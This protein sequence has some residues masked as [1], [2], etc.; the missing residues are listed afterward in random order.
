M[1]TDRSCRR[2]T[3]RFII[4]LNARGGPDLC[5]SIDELSRQRHCEFCDPRHLEQLIF[6]E[7]SQKD[8]GADTRRPT[9]LH[10]A[11]LCCFVLTVVSSLVYPYFHL[12]FYAR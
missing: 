8:T 9:D 1:S 7:G 5:R 3:N 6:V 2:P 10:T 11:V 12:C 4:K